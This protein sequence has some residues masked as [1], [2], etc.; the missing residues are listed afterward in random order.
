MVKDVK[1]FAQ[2]LYEIGES[3]NKDGLFLEQLISI[4]DA[5]KDQ[6]EFK[7]ALAHPKISTEEKKT[8]LKQLF[9]NDIDSELM[10]FLTVI[11]AYKLAG[12]L[13][14]V[15]DTYQDIYKEGHHI[16]SLK[17]T[18]AKELSEEQVA[19]IKT[20]LEEKLGHEVELSLYTNPDLIAGI[21]VQGKD[22]LLDNSMK[23]RLDSLKENLK[24]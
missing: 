15:I 13:D 21:R 1:P 18:S 5:L 24:N 19:K 7:Q 11:A 20:M 22:F 4:K 23:N 6:D 17:V 3:E 10:N 16:E 14:E 2:A 9:E 8:W 12:Q